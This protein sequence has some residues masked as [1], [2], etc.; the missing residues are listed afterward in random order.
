MGEYGRGQKRKRRTGVKI[1]LGAILLIVVGIVGYGYSVYHNVNITAETI[2]T[3]VETEVVRDSSVDLNRQHPISI[4]LLGVD[5]GDLGRTEQGRSDSMVLA[6]INPNFQKMTLLSIP[7]DTYAEIVGNG[8]SDKINHAYAFGGTA[9]SINT[10]QKFLDIPIDYYVTVNMAGIQEIVD[11]VEGVDVESPMAFTL[12]NYSFVEGTNHLDGDA[13]LAFA[14][15]RDDDPSGDTGRQGRQ[16]LIIEAV[17]KKIISPNTLTNYQEI[18]ASLS[19]NIETNLQMSDYFA[20]QSNGYIA[21]A[22]NIQQEQL[23]GIGST[24]DDGVYY[25]FTDA[26]ELAR[27]QALLRAELELE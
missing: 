12:G 17:I 22:G 13:A 15:M 3:P 2:H 10:V 7:R 21:A 14:R 16:R 27:V 23:A 6:T 1:F 24:E 25:S 9:M 26:A 4:L 18:L 11:V 5:S 8:T 19:N 20:L